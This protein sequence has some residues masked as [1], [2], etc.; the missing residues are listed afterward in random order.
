MAHTKQAARDAATATLKK[1]A[2]NEPSVVH[3]EIIRGISEENAVASA[4]ALVPF[5]SRRPLEV[6]AVLAWKWNN[7]TYHG[8]TRTEDEAR[9]TVLHACRF[10]DAPQ[11]TPET[12]V[13]VAWSHASL[14]YAPQTEGHTVMPCVAERLSDMI[15]FSGKGKRQA[16]A[17]S[18][19]SAITYTDA[20]APRTTEVSGVTRSFLSFRM[21]VDITDSQHAAAGQLA[22]E[23]LAA[24]TDGAAGSAGMLLSESRKADERLEPIVTPCSSLA[25]GIA[26]NEELK[27]WLAS[28]VLK[29]RKNGHT[30]VQLGTATSQETGRDAPSIINSEPPPLLTICDV[31]VEVASAS[32]AAEAE[33]DERGEKSE[34]S[35]GVGLSVCGDAAVRVPEA[36]KTVMRRD[37]VE[38]RGYLYARAMLWAGISQSSFICKSWT[39]THPFKRGLT[40]CFVRSKRRSRH[41]GVQRQLGHRLVQEDRGAFLPRSIWLPLTDA[42]VHRSPTCI[43]GPAAASSTPIAWV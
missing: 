22:E 17:A 12:E 35:L 14:Q 5:V 32:E 4:K 19:M 15:E 16:V 34:A 26:L 41:L 24:A 27:G 30:K 10:S 37:D 42:R 3:N 28:P 13:A 2:G 20:E 33:M 39:R 40:R 6:P 8:V 1:Q 7:T 21:F 29:T 9:F 31:H 11:P 36:A 23:I 38:A 43:A 18:R 25:V